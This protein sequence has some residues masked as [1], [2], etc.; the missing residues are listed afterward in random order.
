MDIKVTNISPLIGSRIGLGK[1]D[2]LSR[3]YAEA[4]RRGQGRR[5]LIRVNGRIVTPFRYC[6]ETQ[7]GLSQ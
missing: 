5:W 6:P 7:S 3:F 1:K 2:L 4:I